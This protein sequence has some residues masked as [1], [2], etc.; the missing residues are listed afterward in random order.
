MLQKVIVGLLALTV[1]GAAGVGIYDSTKNDTYSEQM[2]VL[3]KPAADETVAV[4]VNAASDPSENAPAD[5]AANVA[6]VQP[7]GPDAAPQIAPTATPE[8][9]IASGAM[10]GAGP[11]QTE[12]QQAV[13][14]VGEPWAAVGTITALDTAGMTLTLSDGSAI[15]VE[16]GPSHYWQNQ[17]VTL[18][19]GESVTVEG[20]FN[21]DQYH[22]ATVTKIDGSKLAVRTADGLPLW[23]GGA[24]GGDSGQN[25]ATAGNGQTDIQVAA[26]DWITV[27][28]TVTAVDAA[29]LTIQTQAGEMLMLQLGEPSFMQ[30]QG[31]A[32]APGDAISALG[33]WQDTMF[34]AGEITK[35]ATGERLMLLDPNGRPL[36]G[37]PG[38]AGNRGGQ[39]G[40]STTGQTQSTTAQ[41]QAGQGQGGQGGGNQGQGQGQGQN[42]GIQV[43]ATQWETLTGHVTMVEPLAFTIQLQNGQTVRV[44]LG[45]VDFWS[46]EG[47]WFSINDQLAVDGYWLNGQFEAGV[48]MLGNGQ[49]L[50]IRD[51]YGRLLWVDSTQAGQGQGGQGG[52]N[53]GQGGQGSQGQGSQGGG[54][55]YR[56]G[57]T[58]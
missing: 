56:G 22:A 16:L 58:S 27:E 54:N 9:A 43:P 51:Q 8:I 13:D 1:I 26:E 50:T 17:A 57:R 35:L 30:Q 38:R 34:R 41:G 4:P 18:V 3:A 46:Q 45:E 7:A 2:Q 47:L 28:G 24:S 21:G 15:Y 19:E 14:M 55:G 39:A 29:S 23:S 31:I 48:V 11:V 10:D 25:G 52:G 32:F 44:M 5:T 40:A 12:Q 36:W 20:F 42:Q 6:D 37:G 53:Q 49:Q 33:F